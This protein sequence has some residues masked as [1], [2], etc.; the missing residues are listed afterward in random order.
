MAIKAKKVAEIADDQFEVKVTVIV[1]IQYR[2]DHPGCRDALEIVYGALCSKKKCIPDGSKLYGHEAR[3][4]DA[5]DLRRR[6]RANAKKQ[7]ERDARMQP[8]RPAARLT[9]PEQEKADG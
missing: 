1:G 6:Q 2:G 4:F 3:V 5:K 8:I 9:R 7:A